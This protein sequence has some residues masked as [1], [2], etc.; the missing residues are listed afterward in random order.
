MSNDKKKISQSKQDLLAK[1]LAPVYRKIGA[2][3][4]FIGLITLLVGLWID[5]TYKTQPF[6]TIGLVIISAPIVIWFNSRTIKHQI[7]Q[8]LDQNKDKTN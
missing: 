1:K 5:R 3:T 7:N 6:F 2:L 8:I 4:F